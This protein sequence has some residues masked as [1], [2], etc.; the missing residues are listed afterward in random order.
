M[1]RSRTCHLFLLFR[2]GAACGFNSLFLTYFLNIS[3]SYWHSSVRAAESASSSRRFFTRSCTLV[4]TSY[5]LQFWSRSREGNVENHF[6]IQQTLVIRPISKSLARCTLFR[7]RGGQREVSS[8]GTNHN[9]CHFT[10][11]T[12]KRNYKIYKLKSK[13]KSAKRTEVS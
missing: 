2:P 6:Y 1:S 8:P 4:I 9:F 3:V 5:L 13:R 12:K 7:G 10:S 11:H